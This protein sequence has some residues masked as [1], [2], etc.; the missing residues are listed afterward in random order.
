MYDKIASLDRLIERDKEETRLEHEY[1]WALVNQNKDQREKITQKIAQK[2]NVS[3]ITSK[4]VFHL[5]FQA[6]EIPKSKLTDLQRAKAKMEK[7]Q[8][9]ETDKL[10]AERKK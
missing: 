10:S 5:L 7:D 9:K 4:L 3:N 6:M 1:I 8:L 2:E